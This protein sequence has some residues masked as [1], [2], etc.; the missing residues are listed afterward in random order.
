MT[1]N[2]RQKEWSFGAIAKTFALWVPPVKL[3]GER[4]V[5][6]MPKGETWPGPPS[7]RLTKAEKASLKEQQADDFLHGKK[8]LLAHIPL[9]LRVVNGRLPSRPKELEAAGWRTFPRHVPKSLLPD[10]ANLIREDPPSQKTR[11]R[12]LDFALSWGPL[13]ACSVHDSCLYSP[14]GEGKFRPQHNPPGLLE[15]NLKLSEIP[16]M[17]EARELFAVLAHYASEG[18]LPPDVVDAFAKQPTPPEVLEYLEIKEDVPGFGV[19]SFSMPGINGLFT[20]KRFLLPCAWSGSESIREWVFWSKYIKFLFSDLDSIS[21]VHYV[22][23]LNRLPYGPAVHLEFI[24]GEKKPRLTLNPGHGFLRLIFHQ[25]A[26]H[27]AG[28]TEYPRCD[29]CKE[30]FIPERRAPKTGQRHYCPPCRDGRAANRHYM[31]T[32]NPKKSRS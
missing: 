9:E 20:V 17:D 19:P 15:T 8:D 10:F 7:R 11:E 29:E 14:E 16:C 22:N 18:E 4:L 13:W 12:I 24:K 6:S 1:K 31:R 28:I 26:E 30:L 3:D 25:L 21:S 23:R 2:P 5:Y 27:L 32:Y